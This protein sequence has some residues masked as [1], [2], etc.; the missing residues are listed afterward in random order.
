MVYTTFAM[1][2]GNEYYTIN[3]LLHW[4]RQ[5]IMFTSNYNYYIFPVCNPYGYESCEVNKEFIRD[6]VVEV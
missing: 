6:L 1:T 5:P 2:T 4:L 3:V